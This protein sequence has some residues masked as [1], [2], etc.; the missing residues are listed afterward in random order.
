[1]EHQNVGRFYTVHLGKFGSPENTVI[2]FKGSKM[3]WL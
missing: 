3:I 1:M 2:A